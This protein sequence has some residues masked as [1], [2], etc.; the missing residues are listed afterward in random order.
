MVRAWGSAEF[1]TVDTEGYPAATLLP[2]MWSGDTVIAHL[3]KANQQWKG[4]ADGDRALLICGGPQAY[5]SPS[6]Y[7][8]KA[9]HHRVVPTWNYSAVHLTGTVTLH[10]DADWLRGA[11]GALTDQHEGARPAPWAVSDAPERFIDGQ[12]RGIVGLEMRITRV[13]G[14]AKLSQNR[15]VADRTGVVRGLAEDPQRTR[16]GGPG[17]GPAD[18]VGQQMSASLERPD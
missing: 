4:I 14:K 3:A 9:E 12:L 5:I 17:R 13:E 7:A 2:I 16:H 10:H 1:V 8:G 18:S 15:S 6:W 11:V